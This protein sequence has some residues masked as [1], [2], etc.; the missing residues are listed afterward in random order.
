M[1]PLDDPKQPRSTLDSARARILAARS[2]AARQERKQQRDTPPL[3]SPEH[4]RQRL[5]IVSDMGIA[6]LL[7]G[8]AVNGQASLVREWLN[9]WSA[10]LDLKRLK[11]LEQRV[12]ELEAELAARAAGP[13][14]VAP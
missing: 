13:R 10:E 4:A 5:A 12:K 8:S 1:S 14:R 7:S 3:D 6:G 9:L 11:L 2:V